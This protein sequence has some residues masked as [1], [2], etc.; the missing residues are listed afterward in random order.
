MGG[1]TA[2]WPERPLLGTALRAWGRG[3]GPGARGVLEA[4]TP[5]LVTSLQVL[6]ISGSFTDGR[7]PLLQAPISCYPEL[8]WVEEEAGPACGAGR[9]QKAASFLLWE[10]LNR[11]P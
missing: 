1:G 11:R 7:P 10:E 8:Q 9:P 5:P 3:L 4:L 2:R 6:P